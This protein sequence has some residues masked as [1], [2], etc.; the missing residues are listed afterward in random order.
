LETPLK[1]DK[2]ALNAHAFKLDYE[3][4]NKR[5]SVRKGASVALVVVLAAF[6]ALVI[7]GCTIPSFSIEIFGLVGIAV[8]SGNSFEEAKTSYS[9]FHLAGMIMEQGRYL[10]TASDL[11][12]LGTFASLLVITVFIVPLAQA[13]SLLVQWFAPM[14]KRQR[15]M[16]MVFNEIAS[17]WQYMEVYVLSII[18][19][20]WQL[21][22][23]SEFM[24]NDYCEPLKDTFSSLA[25]FGIMAT[26]DAQC[27][28]VN[29]S[30]ESAS[31]ILLSASL[32]LVVICHFV[33]TATQQKVQDDRTP[34]DRR[35][36]TDRW[37]SKS[38]GAEDEET[39]STANISPIPWRFTDF[40][41]VATTVRSVHEGS[42]GSAE[43]SHVASV[44]TAVCREGNV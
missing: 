34:T 30:V 12:G 43:E 42:E 27:F 33:G 40:Y 14:T 39:K 17:A 21:G 41:A 16:N 32:I 15:S 2:E 24:L 26:E 35:R 7:V 11:V 19:A 10:N 37:S 28:R 13:V 1:A 36:H 4:S 29:A 23:V 20:A 18:V 44:D 3:A 22:D 5:A 38:I 8:E 9:V 31:W 25:Y 6:V